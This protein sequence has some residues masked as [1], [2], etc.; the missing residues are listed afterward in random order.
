MEVPSI[1]VEAY[2]RAFF[3]LA[4]LWAQALVPSQVFAYGGV[5][6][7]WGA[8]GS[9]DGYESRRFAC[10]TNADSATL[11]GS[12]VADYPDRPGFV[13]L[14]AVVDIFFDGLI[15]DWWAVANP[16]SFRENALSVSFDYSGDACT[17]PWLGSA[18]G[19]I[20]HYDPPISSNT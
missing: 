1:R 4:A 2:M 14:D 6:L 5:N 12:I 9:A 17:H 3:V 16:G 19:G 7:N 15:P 11:V 18:S 10:D 13:G 8:C 20:T